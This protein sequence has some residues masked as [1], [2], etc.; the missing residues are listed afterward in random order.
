MEGKLK[1]A[2]RSRTWLTHI[3]I[4]INI[5]HAFALKKNFSVFPQ[6]EMVEKQ[7]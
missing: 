6:H 4:Y 1:M 3:Y 2:A 5:E 7:K